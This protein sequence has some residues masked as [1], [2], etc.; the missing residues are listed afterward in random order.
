MHYNSANQVIASNIAPG[1]FLYDAAGNVLNDGVNRYVYDAAGR[2]CAVQD[3]TTGAMTGYVYD[4]ESR[5]LAKGSIST[6][7]CD[8]TVNGFTPAAEYIVGMSGEQLGETDGK[9]TLRH[10]NV[11]ANGQLLATYEGSNSNWYY[12]LNDWLGTKRVEANAD[13][14][15]AASFLSL[16]FGDGLTQQG[17][18]PDAT[19]HHFTGKVRDNESGNDYFGARYFGSTMGRFL[20]PDPTGGHTEDPQTLNKYM[21]VRNNPLTLTDPTGLDFYQGCSSVS[22]DPPCQQVQLGVNGVV[23]L[24]GLIT[25]G[26]F[27]PTVITSASLSD[28]N[29]GNTAA[30]NG[31]GVMITTGTGTSNQQT[32]QGIFIANTP[33]ADIQGQG[34]GWSQFSFHIDSSDVSHGVI[35]SGKATYNGN[36]GNQGM[37]DTLNSLTAGGHG[38]WHYPLEDYYNIF[39]LGDTNIRFSTGSD[40]V[41]E[42]YGPSP[43]FPVP[44]SGTTVPHFHID[45]RTGPGHLNC[46]VRGGRMLLIWLTVLAAVLSGL[47]L[48]LF[49]TEGKTLLGIRKIIFV[50]GAAA[51]LGSTIVL[52]VFLITAH[53]MARG[54]MCPIDLDRVYPVFSMLGLGLLAAVLALFGRRSSRVLLL[55]AGL[56]VAYLWYIAGLAVSP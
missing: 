49:R 47:G 29:S 52:L 2:V 25:N 30:V 46:A 9:L 3:I 50:T 38:P 10:G 1:G 55:V 7:S 14:S 17:T 41:H 45:S 31:S 16:P 13:G 22:A 6:L 39:H 42:N 5:R 43:H 18:G 11:F 40:P 15:I 26:Q 8:I 56:L 12:N 21:Y 27:Q 35:D 4:G 44:S 54:T 32:G 53:Q 36:G 23:L 28:P 33:A 34:A 20:S 48:L 19:E 51:N 24:Q 37:L